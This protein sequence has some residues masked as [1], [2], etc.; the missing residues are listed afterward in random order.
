MNS[1]FD[2]RYI[3][4]IS[5]YNNE[6]FTIELSGNEKELKELIATLLKVNPKNIKGMRDI[7]GNYYTISSAIKNY[8]LT[9]DFSKYYV[10]LVN[11]FIGKNNKNNVFNNNIIL[12]D[13][14]IIN[15]SSQNNN[16]YFNN[17]M[18]YN[19]N[20]LNLNNNFI[21]N[22]NNNINNNNNNNE[23][24]K[25]CDKLYNNKYINEKKYMKLKEYINDNNQEII[26]LFKLYNSY[27]K[28][29]NKLNI[30][31]KPIL[32]RYKNKNHISNSSIY[33]SNKYEYYNN[34]ID[35]LSKK[36]NSNLYNNEK[37]TSSYL[38]KEILCD[39]E[40]LINILDNY[41]KNDNKNVLNDLNNFLKKHNN[42]ILIDVKENNNI[43]DEIDLYQKNIS[44][45]FTTENIRL[46]FIV[47]FKYDTIKLNNKKKLNL[48]KNV[49]L[50]N[51]PN[52]IDNNSKLEIKKY[53]LNEVQNKLLKNFNDNEKNIYNNLVDNNDENILNEFN[54][55]LTH[56]NLNILNK[57][58]LNFIK[59]S[60]NDNN[61]NNIN[62]NNNNNNNNKSSENLENSNNNDDSELI[63]KYYHSS[64]F[65][66]SKLSEDNSY[67]NKEKNNKNN[68]NKNKNKNNNKNDNNNNNNNNDYIINNI[69]NNKVFR[70]IHRNNK[71]TNNFN[72]N[73]YNFPLFESNKNLN[74]KLN[75]FINMI[76]NMAFDEIHKKKILDL[77][78]NNNEELM[79][80]FQKFQKNKLSLTKNVLLK[81]INEQNR[82]NKINNTTKLKQ[83]NLKIDEE[84][85]ENEL[86]FENF[87][88]SLLS[89]KKI[90]KN[91]YYFLSKEFSN[92][93]Q[94]LNSIW[95]SYIIN[96]DEE[97]EKENLIESIELFLNKHNEEIKNFNYNNVKKYSIQ[98]PSS[99]KNFKSEL[100]NYLKGKERG[101]IKNKQK[102]IIDLLIKENLLHNKNFQFYYDKIENEDNIIIS[103]FEVF[104]ITLNH[105][106]FADTLDI[107][108]NLE[109]IAKA[110]KKKEKEKENCFKRNSKSFTD[111]S[112]IIKKINEVE[113]K[114][115]NTKSEEINK[116]KDNK[117]LLK[118]LIKNFNENEKKMLINE[119]DN[120][121]EMLLSI[122]ETYDSDDEDE[123]IDDIKLI[124]DKLSKLS[125]KNRNN[126]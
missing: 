126:K 104:S 9:N 101:E 19:N 2:I 25:I 29:L 100:V 47:M 20:P 46:D 39:N 80:I 85:I 73:I 103:A 79:K 95:E 123:C 118:N 121:N 7:Y 76:N 62:I 91:Q 72:N 84:K 125:N 82:D 93:N 8:H 71:S 70:L 75:E 63:L 109:E 68:K 14:L 23:Y 56:K 105:L 4:I 40:E 122:L 35:D 81:L 41:K 65:S 77:F 12:N 45:I 49:F 113:K 111:N 50:I 83:I 52:K 87:I 98:T 28:D 36:I 107:L 74:K 86:S 78:R 89:N 44:K 92:N 6:M 90:N 55:F 99:I 1:F 31:L 11:N 38:K 51:D 120:N 59:N 37:T 67:N 3:K 112:K 13:D 17:I 34:I 88:N 24:I 94:I 60:V 21:N 5:P 117:E 119:Y 69:D 54:K 26:T 61:N 114:I 18:N 66:S 30:Q 27:G 22:N 43:N 53:Y 106:D 57:N 32:S 10:I 115:N 16:N 33:D 97:D 110:N 96:P 42:S 108:Y 64:S 124:V 48:F 15:N 102:R 58:L 116:I